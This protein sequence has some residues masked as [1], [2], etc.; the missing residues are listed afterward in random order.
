[1]KIIVLGANHAGT[2]FMRTIASLG[3]K[4]EIVTYDKNNNISF[5][6]CG[7]ALWVSDEF[8]DPKG[9]F[10]SSPEEL[11]SLNIDVKMEH[12]VIKVDIE[13]KEVEVK[14]L[15][16]GEIFTDNYDKLI[17]SGGTWP[18]TPPFP[19]ADLENIY[20]SKIF[21]HA[22]IIKKMSKDDQIKDVVVIGAGYIGVE[23]SEAFIKANKKVTLIDMS[24]NVI[25]KYFD[26][27]FTNEM[28]SR[29]EQKGL[30]LALKEKVKEIKGT[31]G[32]V[33]SVITDKGE[34]KA[35]LVI[36]SIG[37]VP[38]TQLVADQLELEPKSKALLVNKFMQTSNKDVYGLG[39]SVALINNAIDQPCHVAL[40]TN[41][42]K[43]GIVAAHHINGT[44]LPF[45]GIQG[46]NGINVF[47]CSFASTGI[48]SELA[49]L[50]GIDYG[51]SFLKDKDRPEWMHNSEDVQFK[52]IYEKKTLR[53]LG[54]QV[55]TF[56]KQ[57]H[58]ESIFALSL[59]ISKKMTLQE[60]ALMDFYFLPHYNKPFN[61]ILQTALNAIKKEL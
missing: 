49:E 56:G 44:N 18:I 43:T 11:R 9:L 54:A 16:T 48:S 37:F 52:L 31:N 29:M 13:N 58:S 47:G 24:G 57:N 21:Q 51:V 41:A 60:L 4:H 19:G 22:Q 26:K 45:P 1:M 42:V 50:H 6:G 34:Y 3:K 46:T 39:D 23:L 5:L 7:I 17:Y 38:Q 35:D 53:L 15:K 27:E 20:L 32:K 12:E 36:M 40:A 28:E 8:E 14:N 59:A 10:Y 2:S 25:G 61:Y 55:G 30:K 33:S